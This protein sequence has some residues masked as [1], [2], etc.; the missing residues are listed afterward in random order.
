MNTRTDVTTDMATS[1]CIPA[2]FSCHV[3]LSSNFFIFSTVGLFYWNIG[4]EFQYKEYSNTNQILQMHA[5]VAF[6]LLINHKLK[7]LIGNT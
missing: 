6:G 3:L 1:P 2:F 4:D 7:V 5:Q